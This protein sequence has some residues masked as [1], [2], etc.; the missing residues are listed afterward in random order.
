[1]AL[2]L[3]TQTPLLRNIQAPDIPS[4]LEC[5]RAREQSFSKGQTS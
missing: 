1:M 4:M 2:P 5:L 3:L